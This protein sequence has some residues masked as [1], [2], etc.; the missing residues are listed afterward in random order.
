MFVIDEVIVEDQIADQRFACDIVQCKGACC[1]LP[2]GRGAPLEDDELIELEQAFPLAKKYLSEKHLRAIEHTGMF[3]GEAGSYA[4]T[5]VDDS[6]CVFVYYEDSI[7]R[8]SLER[9]FI[10]GETKWRKPLSCHLFP[11]RI[12]P[13]GI[14][15]LRY[16]KIPECSSAIERGNKKNI[17]LYDFLKDALIRKFGET[18]YNEFRK[19]CLTHEQVCSE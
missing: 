1:T 9:A 6:A 7:A 19:E 11:I 5:C 3:E 14:E 8:C 4:T 16:E 13:N 2:G 17:P 18:W 10:N 15:R 12:S